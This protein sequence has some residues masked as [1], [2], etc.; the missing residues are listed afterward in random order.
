MP[1]SSLR[2]ILC[3]FFHHHSG[4]YHR[5]RMTAWAMWFSTVLNTGLSFLN[6]VKNPGRGWGLFFNGIKYLPVILERSEESGQRL[7]VLNTFLQLSYAGFFA[8]S[9]IMFFLL[10]SF[11]FLPPL[12]NDGRGD[13]FFYGNTFLPVIYSMPD[14]SL[15]VILYFFFY[16][17]FG[18]C[19]RSRMTAGVLRFLVLHSC[20]S[21]LNGRKMRSGIAL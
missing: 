12:K 5:S 2:V 16:H 9:Q 3:F 8:K 11:R 4:S 14:S 19:R 7:Q 1:D 17:H 15:R 20:L 18:S 6:E 13:A 21:F 10:S